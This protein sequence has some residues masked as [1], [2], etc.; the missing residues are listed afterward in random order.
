M[1]DNMSVKSYSVA[2]DYP[3]TTPAGRVVN[4]P[5]SR[6]WAFSKEKLAELIADN[7]IWFG[8]KGDGVPRIKRFLNEV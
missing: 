5:S 4:P 1:S 2:T 6:C 7:R 3:I 8:A